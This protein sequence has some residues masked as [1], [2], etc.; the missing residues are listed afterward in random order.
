MKW[1]ECYEL[2]VPII[3]KQHKE[4]FNRLDIL[5]ES[6]KKGNTEVE[7]VNALKFLAGYVKHHF[8]AE[9]EVMRIIAYNG[10]AEHK[11]LHTELVYSLVHTIEAIKKKQHLNVYELEQFVR[12][13]ICDHILKEDLKI[14]ECI[15]E[16]KN[17]NSF[18]K[19]ITKENSHALISDILNICE[20]I[21]GRRINKMLA[22]KDAEIKMRGE[23]DHYLQ[24]FKYTTLSE[25]YDKIKVL[26]TLVA[27]GYVEDEVI[28]S[29]LKKVMTCELLAKV[30][31]VSEDKEYDAMMIRVFQEEKI[32]TD[33]QVDELHKKC[34]VMH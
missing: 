13:W 7:I 29:F 9:E 23:L 20:D 15:Q 12:E 22:P 18:I 16:K 11:I 25:L 8:A 3:D 34:L 26:K 33:L 30:I 6:F 14:K 19:N 2:H 5:R 28:D 27:R 32:L 1:N 10:L 31:E 4:L 21:D 24:E 17:H